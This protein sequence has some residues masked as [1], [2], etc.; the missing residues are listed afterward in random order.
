MRLDRLPASIRLAVAG[1]CV[2]YLAFAAAA[3]A[4]LW[5]QAGGGRLPTAQRVLERYHGRPD[6][7]H[8]HRALDP[9]LPEEDPHAMYPFAGEDEAERARHRDV[10]LA[11]VEAGAPRE[12]FGPVREIVTNPL[13]CAQ[14]H[15]PEGSA[16]FPLVTYEDVL[17]YARRGEGMAWSTLLTSAHNHL[18]AFG[19][20]A[21]LLSLGLALS[22]APGRLRTLLIVLAFLG[23]L[24]DVGGW[25][26]T[27]QLGAPW[28]L[29]VMAGGA[30]FGAA[31]VAMAAY[32]LLDILRG[33]RRRRPG[34]S[35]A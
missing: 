18:F 7:S 26:L 8:L 16:P 3:Q 20:A 34:A 19:V 17:P 4:Q 13:L 9:T 14:C 2:V 25:F 31:T 33:D 10:I 6:D 23:P 5:H 22:R 29:V 32:V 21:L 1:F 15:E 24:L 30:M 12:G 35:D 27:R 11:W 28:H